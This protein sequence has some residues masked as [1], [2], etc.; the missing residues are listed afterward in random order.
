MCNTRTIRN[1]V[2][3][4]Y[5]TRHEEQVGSAF[6]LLAK[7]SSKLPWPAYQFLLPLSLP[8]LPPGRR[9]IQHLEH[10]DWSEAAT[11][12]PKQGETGRFLLLPQTCTTGEPGPLRGS[13]TA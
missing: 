2:T 10:N 12:T 1:S 6:V 5:A 11:S 3:R 7:N 8:A 9:V 13:G 4:G